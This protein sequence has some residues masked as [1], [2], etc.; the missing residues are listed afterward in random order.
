MV[1][2]DYR[3]SNE[4]RGGG[5]RRYSDINERDF[6]GRSSYPEDDYGVGYGEEGLTN[7]SRRYVGQQFR[8]S[9]RGPENYGEYRSYGGGE[10]DSYGGG[11]AGRGSMGGGQYRSHE[12]W[13][14]GLEDDYERSSYGRSQGY[15][16][17]ETALGRD[18]G[19]RGYRS[20]DYG[21]EDN[22]D[23][24]R[25][26]WDRASDEVQSWFEIGRAYV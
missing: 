8:G 21:H 3:W 6:Y 25:G 13:G 10:R 23:R 19:D 18:Y 15:G 20:R 5:T 2:R 22:R 17:R 9:G 7:Y 12:Q 16:S 26:W 24:D 4:H 11:A 14:R 1:D